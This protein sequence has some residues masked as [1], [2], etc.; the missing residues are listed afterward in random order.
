MGKISSY[1]KITELTSDHLLLVD[2]SSGTKTIKA[3]DL[4]RS[5]KSFGPDQ[6]S[7]FW[8][9]HSLLNGNARNVTAG[10]FNVTVLKIFLESVEVLPIN[11]AYATVE[12]AGFISKA[13]N[14]VYKGADAFFYDIFRANISNTVNMGSY[15]TYNAINN[16]IFLSRPGYTKAS[17]HGV[18]VKFTSSSAVDNVKPGSQNL[19]LNIKSWYNDDTN[20][21]NLLSDDI[22]ITLTDLN[23][24]Y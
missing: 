2:G 3:G 12:A 6:T 11:I 10:G 19:I 5:L 15:G 24:L 18:C 22:N 1:P 16:G 9:R 13:Q 17:L 14:G 21:S 4:A 7:H 20:D 8:K 23:V